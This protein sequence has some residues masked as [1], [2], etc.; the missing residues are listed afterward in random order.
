M[1]QRN[2]EWEFATDDAR[3]LATWRDWDVDT[4]YWDDWDGMDVEEVSND[5]G[6]SPCAWMDLDGERFFDAWLEDGGS[7]DVEFEMDFDEGRGVVL[8]EGGDEDDGFLLIFEDSADE[9]LSVWSMED[10]YEMVEAG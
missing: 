6:E 5:R 10:G 7:S 3:D 4:V 9:D 2:R 8:L 1:R